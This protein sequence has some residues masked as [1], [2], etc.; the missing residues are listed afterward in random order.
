MRALLAEEVEEL[1]IAAD[2]T[3]PLRATDPTLLRSTDADTPSG[4]AAMVILKRL[5][6]R[7]CLVQVPP[8]PFPPPRGYWVECYAITALGRLALSVSLPFKEVSHG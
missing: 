6:L 7:G 1:R 5:A 4:A 2:P 8:P 3:L